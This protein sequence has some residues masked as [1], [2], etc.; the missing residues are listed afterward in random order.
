MT[1]CGKNQ[2]MFDFKISEMSNSY[3]IFSDWLHTGFSITESC[4]TPMET[5]QTN[6]QSIIKNGISVLQFNQNIQAQYHNSLSFH[7]TKNAVEQNVITQQELQKTFEIRFFECL[8]SVK[9]KVELNPTMSELKNSL[10]EIEKISNENVKE[11]FKNRVLFHFL[12]C[13]APNNNNIF[14][15]NA[16]K[17][18]LHKFSFENF[19][20]ATITCGLNIIDCDCAGSLFQLYSSLITES[21]DIGNDVDLFVFFACGANENLPVSPGLPMN[22]FSACLTIPAKIALLFHSFHY[23]CF[24]NGPLHPLNSETIDDIPNDILEEITVTLHNIV[25]TMAFDLFKPDMFNRL[26]KT[27]KTLTDFICNFY[28]ATRIM[29]FYGVHPLSYPVL[30]D[31]RKHQL[32][33]SFDLRLDSALVR[34]NSP[35]PYSELSFET[36]LN[37][38]LQTLNNFM[39][40]PK[41]IQVPS[42]LSSI[43]TALK[44]ESL[45]LDVCHTLARYVDKSPDNIRHVLCFPITENLLNLFQKNVKNDDILLCFSKILFFKNIIPLENSLSE[46]IYP[47]LF[48]ENPLLPLII[49]TLCVRKNINLISHF[50]NKWIRRIVQLFSNK[51]TDVRLWCLLFISSIVQIIKPSDVI[52]KIIKLLNDEYPEVRIASLYTISLFIGKIDEKKILLIF[53][54][55]KLYEDPNPSVRIQLIVTLQKFVKCKEVDEI[56]GFME[57][58]PYPGIHKV[59]FEKNEVRSFAYEYFISSILNQIYEIIQ[60]PGKRIVEVQPISISLEPIIKKDY[61]LSYF[62]RL[63]NGPIISYECSITSNFSNLNENQFVFGTE[64]G[65]VTC[66]SWYDQQVRFSRRISPKPITHI[67]NITNSNFPLTLVSNTDGYLYMLQFSDVVFN[68][69]SSFKAYDG[70]FEFECDEYDHKL[71]TYFKG[72]NDALIYDLD[73]EKM[74]GE[75]K[76]SNGSIKSIKSIPKLS[77]MIAVCNDKL[78]F[79][80]VRAG[81][82]SIFQYGQNVIDIGIIDKSPTMFGIGYNDSA[83]FIDIRSPDCVSKYHILPNNYQALSFTV[84]NYSGFAALG[85][86]KGLYVVDLET[87]SQQSFKSMTQ[88][89]SKRKFRNVNQCIFHP[90]KMKLSFIQEN[91]EIIYLIEDN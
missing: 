68:L 10:D 2:Q 27:D 21:R 84:Q 58:D 14:V 59:L 64:L 52:D 9:M 76:S 71:Y 60:T 12:S 37:Q 87:G 15:L 78:E 74:I 50:E 4:I 25:E 13:S 66:L 77:N 46:L 32:W 82:K 89:F 7:W 80:D 86:E 83:G 6:F 1:P 42:L 16:D 75:L 33:H 73:R 3:P 24:K 35:L 69:A 51:Y 22:L 47:L 26:F 38:S 43:S 36:Y 11:G 23:Y 79:Y 85:Y 8:P 61:H 40:M 29:L 18:A 30:P 72:K 17:K 39:D 34:I 49:A 55:L 67:Q 53:M 81:N 48:N 90:Y 31:L 63:V 88:L 57:F 62:Q 20:K 91:H 28:L 41:D 19:I 5:N 45:Q 54:K 56:F 44:I 65:G 70:K